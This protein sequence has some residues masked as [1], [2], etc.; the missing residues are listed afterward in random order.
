M[1]PR[2]LLNVRI[3]GLMQH[4]KQKTYLTSVLWSDKN[5]VLVYRTFE[6]FKKFHKKV[7]KYFPLE[8]G[9][10]KKSNRVL[11]KFE[12]VSLKE[13]RHSKVSKSMLRMAMLE[14][15]CSELL[16]SSVTIATDEGVMQFFLP[17]D[18]DLTPSTPKDSVIIMPSA[19]GRKKSTWRR[20]D[21]SGLQNIT[22]PVALEYYKCIATYEG[23]DTK[24]K[25][26]KV[27]ESETVDVINKNTSG[28]WLVENER[29][30]VAWFPAP[31]LRKSLTSTLSRTS[32]TEINVS[33]LESQYYAA[34]DYQATDD[35]ELSLQVGIMVEVLRKSI[36]GWW[37][38]SYNGECGYVPSVYLQPYRNPHSK[39]QLLNNSSS[40]NLAR[41][42][43]DAHHRLSNVDQTNHNDYSST[44][45]TRKQLERQRSKSVNCLSDENRSQMESPFFHLNQTASLSDDASSSTVSSAKSSSSVDSCSDGLNTSQGSDGVFERND[46][47]SPPQSA[48]KNLNSSFEKQMELSPDPEISPGEN[49]SEANLVPKIPPRPQRDELLTRCTTLTKNMVLKSHNYFGFKHSEMF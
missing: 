42:V 11:P 10:I 4:K 9:R 8:A 34:K 13:R 47:L 40:P 16:R 2:Y 21:G 30:Q 41:P 39:F 5:D 36:D 45:P 23:K 14:N 19:F 18:K 24:N 48:S 22:Q 49:I 46:F 17:T 38:A 7:E 43:K 32:D 12:D 28:W 33:S 25:P 27:M 15:Y 44:K 29:K 1:N 3:I 26:F 35:D 31:Y 20:T 37:L 6:E